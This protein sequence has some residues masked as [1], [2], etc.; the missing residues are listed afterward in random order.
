MLKGIK[1]RLYPNKEQTNDLNSLLGAYRFVYNQSLNLKKETYK[2]TNKILTYNETSKY[3][4]GDM[5]IQYPWISKHNTKVLKQSIRDLETAYNNFFKQNKGFPV[6]KSKHD[7]QKARFPV[8]AVAKDTFKNDKLNLTTKIKDLNFECSDTDKKYLID[9]KHNIKSVTIT[10][11]KTNKYFASILIDGIV[12]VKSEPINEIIGIDLGIKSLMTLSD[13]EVI[14][15]PKFIRTSEK[16]LKKL[17][18][19][20]SKKT[21]GSKNRDKAKL[22][23]AKAHEKIKNSKNDYIHK[24]TSKIVNENQVIVIEDLNVSGMMKNHKLAKS[25]QELGLHEIKRQLEYKSNWYGRELIF[26]DRW[27]PSSKKCSNC[28]EINKDLN[29]SDR[30]FKCKE[31]DFEIDRDLNASLNIEAEG[32]RLYKE[33]IGQRL[34]ELTLVD[35]PLMGLDSEMSL[36]SNVRMKQEDVSCVE[37]SKLC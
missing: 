25:I 28:G 24:L 31:C 5:K 21:K 29:L 34:P 27:F 30:I 37:I 36:D 22:K 23:L 35:L 14:E 6:F 3:F 9:F 15:N 13:G 33:K 10:R 26:V 20:L 19:Q 12:K 16:Q 32:L 11:T 1:V 4:H 2:N 17:H 8:E 18:K 7:I